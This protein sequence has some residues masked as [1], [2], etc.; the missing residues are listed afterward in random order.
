VLGGTREQVSVKAK[1]GEGLGP[2]GE[3]L[4]LAAE[5]IVLVERQG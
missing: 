5:A 4:A 2:I 3:G 1:T